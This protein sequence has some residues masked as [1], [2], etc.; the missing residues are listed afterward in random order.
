MKSSLCWPAAP[1]PCGCPG[2]R[3]IPSVTPLK[4]TDFSSPSINQVSLA[5]WLGVD[6]WRH[7]ISKLEQR[8]SDSQWLGEAF[9]EAKGIW[10]GASLNSTRY[11]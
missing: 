3:Y 2:V 8:H 11:L 6:L 1:G 7:L 4:R 10:I 5:P 9:E